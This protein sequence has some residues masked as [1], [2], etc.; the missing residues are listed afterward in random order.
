MGS[1][2]RILSRRLTLLCSRYK[3][4]VSLLIL[5]FARAA[6]MSAQTLA[7]PGWV[8]S[9]V[10]VERWWKEAVFLEVGT[11]ERPAGAG[12]GQDHS[13]LAR[14]AASLGDIQT[15]GV[16]AIILRGIDHAD[17]RQG[18]NGRMS[19]TYGTR[20]QFD[21]L[22]QEA[23]SRRIRVVVE[24]DSTEQGDSLASAARFW[25]SR[26][27]T[28]L[29]LR[30]DTSRAS[31]PQQVEVLRAVLRSYVG[32][33]V[34]IAEPSRAQA[35]S[36]EPSPGAAQAAG[37]RTPTS[38]SGQPDLTLLRVRGLGEGGVDVAAVRESLHKAQGHTSGS[39]VELPSG[40]AGASTGAREAESV[41][42]L[43]AGAAI[44]LS[45]DAV[46][47]AQ[48]GGG[49]DQDKGTRTT[50]NEPLV[51]WYRKLLGLHRG[52]PTMRGGEETLL[53][54][55][56]DGALVCVWV[57]RGAGAQAVVAISNL[58]DRPLHTELTKEIAAMHLRGSFLRTLLR[59]D[60]GMG[61]MPL[62]SV[63][64]PP[65]GVYIGELGR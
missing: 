5:L 59:S 49:G 53:N 40:S 47:P 3:V 50:A 29:Y 31:T 56:A 37:R 41:A 39:L 44:A 33:R 45:A 10:R 6:A 21:R 54:H 26:G 36:D 63:S 23:G 24:L 51:D 25:L 19:P 43:S 7:R 65:Y 32:D 4:V 38:A 28:G 2:M 15:F 61:A 62:R 17:D 22:M 30:S 42:L 13:E 35:A 18:E 60:G 8:G 1:G 64:L 12:G 16:D 48:V 57:G 11:T 55:D 27:V 34:L 14:V 58:T 20:E 52:N 9:G 46:G